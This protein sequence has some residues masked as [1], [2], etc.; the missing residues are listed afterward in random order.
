M[1]MG[2]TGDP[3]SDTEIIKRL[4]RA[5]GHL[6]GII[7]M[8]EAGREYLDTANSSIRMKRCLLD[9]GTAKAACRA[10]TPFRR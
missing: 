3:K 8:L 1:S 4:K 5:E 7:A 10:R 2:V 6:R 9:A